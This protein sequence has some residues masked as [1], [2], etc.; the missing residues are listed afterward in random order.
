VFVSLSLSLSQSGGAVGGVTALWAST[1][2]NACSL[3]AN[4]KTSNFGS[5]TFLATK[6]IIGEVLVGKDLTLS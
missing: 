6:R 4:L 1:A 3:L 2:S 5:S